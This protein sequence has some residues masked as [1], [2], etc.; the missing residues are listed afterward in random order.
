MVLAVGSLALLAT[1]T[2]LAPAAPLSPGDAQAPLTAA[3]GAR[4]WTPDKFKS[5][6]TFGD[7]FTDEARAAYFGKHGTAPPTG[8]MGPVVRGPL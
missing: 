4:A 8:W 5:L 2:T 3:G 1:L 6:V 7:S